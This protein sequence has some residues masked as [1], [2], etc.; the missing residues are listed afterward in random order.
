VSVTE[1][2]IKIQYGGSIPWLVFWAIIWFPAALILIATSG[3]FDLEGKTHFI[4]YDGSRGWLIFW[5]II[6]FPIAILLML[7]NGVALITQNQTP[8]TNVPI[9]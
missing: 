2:K 4:R 5:V 1:R 7:L 6:M 3:K 9:V 8:Q